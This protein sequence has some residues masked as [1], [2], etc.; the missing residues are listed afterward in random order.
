MTLQCGVGEGALA[1]HYTPWWFKDLV[2]LE[3][4]NIS[5]GSDFSLHIEAVDLSDAGKYSSAV[6]LLGENGLTEYSVAENKRP[7]MLTVF[8]ESHKIYIG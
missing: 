6:T 2:P 1:E 7:L 5:R 4:A 8:S 3:N